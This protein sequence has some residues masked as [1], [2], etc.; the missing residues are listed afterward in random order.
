MV[1]RIKERLQADEDHRKAR[2]AEEKKRKEFQMSEWE[3]NIT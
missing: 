2:E 3:V 1:K